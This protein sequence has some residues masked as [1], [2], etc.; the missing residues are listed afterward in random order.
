MWCNKAP[1]KVYFTT[2]C[3]GSVMSAVLGSCD[4]IPLNLLP[5]RWNKAVGGKWLTLC[6][7]LKGHQRVLERSHSL[8]IAP[9][10]LSAGQRLWI[11]F[12]SAE[13]FLTLQSLDSPRA[14]FSSLWQ[15]VRMKIHISKLIT[16]KILKL[17]S[18]TWTTVVFPSLVCTIQHR[19]IKCRQNQSACTVG[20]HIMT[21]W[22]HTGV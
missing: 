13:K 17:I 1:V 6:P 8:L 22:S 10:K 4:H 2:S 11:F 3:L 7:Q 16:L 20:A 12:P 9:L 18:K 5:N 14:E 21:F 15:M 19:Q